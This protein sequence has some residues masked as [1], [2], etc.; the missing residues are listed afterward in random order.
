[1]SNEH[2]E[3][4]KELD[5]RYEPKHKTKT[6]TLPKG[7]EVVQTSQNSNNKKTNSKK[8]NTIIIAAVIILAGIWL[9]PGDILDDITVYF[10]EKPAPKQCTP[11][12]VELYKFSDLTSNNSV[13]VEL[14]IVNIGETTA[15]DITIYV[16]VR[17]HNGTILFSD[18]LVLTVLLLRDN[19]TCS[20]IYTIPITQN[21]T[22]ILHTI[23]IEWEL[24][25]TAYSKTTTI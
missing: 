14:W 7:Q 3:I 17:N 4:I 22:C 5:M 1:M 2:D 9:Y 24:G 12:E 13:N 6:A 23:E 16:R 25:R 18:E 15:K 21:E 8:T 10:E 20:A 11:A 19:E